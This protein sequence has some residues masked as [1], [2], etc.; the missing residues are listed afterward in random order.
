MC[1]GEAVHSTFEEGAILAY[2]PRFFVAGV[3]VL[4]DNAVWE[5]EKEKGYVSR[6]LIS[7]FSPPEPL[8]YLILSGNASDVRALLPLGASQSSQEDKQG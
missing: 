6:P 5:P 8:T 2:D 7:R 1:L 3:M 4:W